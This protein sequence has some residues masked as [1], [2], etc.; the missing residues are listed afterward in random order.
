MSLVGN[1]RHKVTIEAQA[2]TQDP[3]TGEIIIGWVT[4]AETMAQIQ[5]MKGS[6]LLRAQELA[7]KVS[8]TITIRYRDGILPEMRVRRANGKLYNIEAVLEDSDSGREW[9]QLQCS[10]GVNAG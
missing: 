1:L 2:Q 7:S 8:V 10:Q 9:I 6:E 3:N 5:P 4:F